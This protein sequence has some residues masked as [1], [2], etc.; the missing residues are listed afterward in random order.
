VPSRFPP[1]FGDFARKWPSSGDKSLVNSLIQT[2]RNLG[3]ARLGAIAFVAFALL[4]FFGFLMIRIS[5]P[6]MAL[7]YSDL[8]PQDA[9]AIIQKLDTLGLPYDITAGGNAIRVPGNQV[10]RLRMTMASEGLPKGGSIG[11]EIFDQKEGFGTTSF[12]QNINHLRALEGELARTISTMS[13]VQSAR[14]HLVLPQRELFTLN[15]QTATASVFIKTR[16]G[17]VLTREQIAAIQNLIAAA[18][19]QLQP[20]RISVV[21]DK[22]NLLARPTDE[23]NPSGIFSGSQDEMRQQYEQTQARKI[24]DLLAR[25]LGFGKVRAKVSADMDFD[26][27]TTSSEIFDP[28]SQVVRSQQSTT[29]DTSSADGNLGTITMGNNLPGGQAQADNMASSNRSNRAEETVNYEINKTVRNQIRETGQVTRLSVAVVVDGTTTI[30][31]DGTKTY[32]PRSPEEL[33]QIKAIVRSAVNFDAHRGDV[34][35]VVNMPFAPDDESLGSGSDS[36]L[37]GLPSTDLMRVAETLMLAFIGLMVVLLIVRPVIKRLLETSAATLASSQRLTTQAPAAGA[38]QL[39]A[40]GL[41]AFSSEQQAQEGESEIEKMIDI[42]RVE[43]Q[44]KASSLRKVGEV[45]DKHPEE[46]VSILRNW[47]YQESR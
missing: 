30:A 16:G 22:G 45:V 24:E 1:F 7:L 46:A 31:E 32:T 21:D 40:P 39:P 41:T 42:S 3:P 9:G 25:T 11:Y 36:L 17:T 12:V 27:V 33:D 29:E 43:G 14:V 44:V 20:N 5:N 4:T 26:R 10:G 18:V 34:L 13:V 19:P 37:M 35:E 15:T 47:I 6:P 8:D 23:N 28:D 38:A 2:L